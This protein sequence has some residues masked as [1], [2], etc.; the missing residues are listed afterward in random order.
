MNAYR[1]LARNPERKRPPGRPRRRYED[2]I[3]KDIRKIDGVVW[4]GFIWLE[5]GTSDGHL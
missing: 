3:K 1:V 2:I 4:T 5:M